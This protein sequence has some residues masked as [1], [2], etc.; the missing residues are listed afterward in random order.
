[1][2]IVELRRYVAVPGR[3]D[4]IVARFRDHT[5]HIFPDHGIH[6]AAIWRDLD[7]PDVLIYTVTFDDRIALDAAWTSFVA[8]PRWIAARDAS[9]ANGPIVERIERTFLQPVA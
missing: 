3:M 9:E 2:S 5:L 7:N 4:D 1:M 6:V 8:D